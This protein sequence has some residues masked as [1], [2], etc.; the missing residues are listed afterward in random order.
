MYPNGRPSRKLIAIA[1]A[2]FSV[3]DDDDEEDE[4]FE[5]EKKDTRAKEITEALNF[6]AIRALT[7]GNRYPTA[8]REASKSIQMLLDADSRAKPERSQLSREPRRS[9]THQDGFTSSIER[10]ENVFHDEE[11]VENG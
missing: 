3:E 9:K 11:M 6:V 5:L 4:A 7:P 1:D 10:T 2:I 8:R